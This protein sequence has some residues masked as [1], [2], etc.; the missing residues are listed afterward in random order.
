MWTRRRTSVRR[1][2]TFGKAQVAFASRARR[3]QGVDGEESVSVVYDSAVDWLTVCDMFKKVSGTRNVAV[4]G[5]TRAGDV[6]SGFRSVAVIRE[7]IVKK[8]NAFVSFKSKGRCRVLQRFVV[9]NKRKE[10]LP[11][12][13]LNRTAF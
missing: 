12:A 3:A 6:F 13:I 2:W 11:V 8:P 1:S 4:M 5:F 10:G 7:D 9:K